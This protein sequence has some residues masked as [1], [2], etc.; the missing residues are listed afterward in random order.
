MSQPAF[1]SKRHEIWYS[2]GAS[3]FNVPARHERGLADG[4]EEEA[5]PAVR[6]AVSEARS[7][8]REARLRRNGTRQP[9][10]HAL[11]EDGRML[12]AVA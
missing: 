9:G 4:A 8:E 7:P 11:G 10:A 1:A 6:K 3:G 12:E 5:S 2:D